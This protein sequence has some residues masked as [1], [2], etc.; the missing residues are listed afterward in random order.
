MKGNPLV[1]FGIF[2]IL[3]VLLW[4]PLKALNQSETELVS[5]QQNAEDV[6]HE[7]IQNNIEVW[8]D[9]KSTKAINKISIRQ[10]E[11]ILLESA[12]EQEDYHNF[13][14]NDFDFGQEIRLNVEVEFA[15]SED[16]LSALEFKFNLGASETQRFYYWSR[17][18]IF[19]KSISLNMQ[20]DRKQE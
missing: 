4:F 2:L 19:T 14:L 17:E 6:K 18:P 12:S 11:K 5:S 10:G 1:E 15:P 7:L 9:L 8:L 13:Y 16:A 20:A 3:W